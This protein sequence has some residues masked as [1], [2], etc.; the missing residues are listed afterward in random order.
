[1]STGDVAPKPDPEPRADAAPPAVRLDRIQRRWGREQ[2]L[3]GV[4]L[5]VAAGRIVALRGRNG[6]GKTT[7]L[8]LLATRL[9]PRAGRAAVFGHDLVKDA[10]A[11][12]RHVAY[13]SV[14]GGSYG[15][16]TARENLRLACTLSGTRPDGVDD[17]LVR[18]GLRPHAERRVRVFSSGM[19]RRLGL[20][21]LLLL[22]ADLWLLDEPYA[23][24][25]DDGRT[26]VDGL[27]DRARE[28]GR[29]VLIAS[30][31][32]DRLADRI[33]ATITIDQGRLVAGDAP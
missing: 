9:R 25:D 5:Q 3:R 4:S 16:L 22:D 2:V 11:V 21:R 20:A 17:A 28:R 18:V 30:H 14:Q 23:S 13:L 33:D 10:A 12:R 6:S 32:P 15:T 31:E 7:L 19:K 1:M 8:R 27:L 29:T 26:L 24:L